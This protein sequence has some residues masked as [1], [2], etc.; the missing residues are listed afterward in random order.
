MKSVQL[1][2]REP[3]PSYMLR[4]AAR[5][6]RDVWPEGYIHFDEAECDGYCLAVVRE[7]AAKEIFDP[8][9]WKVSHGHEF[10]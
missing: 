4:V 2:P 6:I 3:R 1:I 7:A 8:E 9:D 5:Y 10:L